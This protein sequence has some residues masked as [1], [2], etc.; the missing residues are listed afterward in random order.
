LVCRTGNNLP[1][2]L[3]MPLS[4]DRCPGQTFGATYAEAPVLLDAGGESRLQGS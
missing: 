1:L 4:A 3:A 2:T